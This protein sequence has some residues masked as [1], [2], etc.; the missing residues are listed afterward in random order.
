LKTT[1]KSSGV[2]PRKIISPSQT[3]ETVIANPRIGGETPSTGESQAMETIC[4]IGPL[5]KG[6][7]P[8][9]AL[10]IGK[11]T[12]RGSPQF[13]CASGMYAAHRFQ[14]AAAP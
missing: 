3:L 5:A 6:E 11:W 14:E 13:Q 9:G 8:P 7:M 4:K 2:L 12:R 1:G 10:T